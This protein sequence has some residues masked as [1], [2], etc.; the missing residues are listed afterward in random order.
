MRE[1]RK[2]HLE[3]FCVAQ[4]THAGNIPGVPRLFPFG[5]GWWA[6]YQSRLRNGFKVSVQTFLM[7]GVQSANLVYA[8]ALQSHASPMDCTSLGTGTILGYPVEL[9]LKVFHLTGFIF[10]PAFNACLRA[11]TA[12][13]GI[14]PTSYRLS[15]RR[16]D[17]LATWHVLVGQMG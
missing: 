8:R 11:L 12:T 4:P 7:P 10:F 9:G 17:L 3:G 16:L 1:R 14:E 5:T 6:R 15:R 13:G 2:Q